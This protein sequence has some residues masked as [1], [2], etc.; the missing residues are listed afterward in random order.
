LN[1]LNKWN[2]HLCQRCY[3]LIKVLY[4]TNK[5]KFFNYFNT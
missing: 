2:H 4:I 1:V 3:G 5:C